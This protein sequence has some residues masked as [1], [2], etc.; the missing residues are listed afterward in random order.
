MSLR[1]T[2][3]DEQL[4]VVRWCRASFPSQNSPVSY[5]GRLLEESNGG[6]WEL[7]CP[8]RHGDCHPLGGDASS[9]VGSYQLFTALRVPN[10]PSYFPVSLLS[11][12]NF[13][14]ITVFRENSWHR[15]FKMTFETICLI[16]Y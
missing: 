9:L 5:T 3:R 7:P 14:P 16:N 2:R 6:Q 15:I 13:E 10:I 1:S 8:P 4:S 11:A 12:I